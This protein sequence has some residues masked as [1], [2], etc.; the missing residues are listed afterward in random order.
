LER[1]LL[2]VECSLSPGEKE[3]LAIMSNKCANP[4][5]AARRDW[6]GGKLF[7]LDFEIAST[8]GEIQHKAAFVWL[9]RRCAQ[10]MKPRV[11]VTR[12][13]I[14]VLLATFPATIAEKANGS[15]WVN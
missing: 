9:C 8:A 12:N 1:K 4:S 3:A 5:C 15:A 6:N 7:R 11:E 13:K 2:H 14:R 10:Q